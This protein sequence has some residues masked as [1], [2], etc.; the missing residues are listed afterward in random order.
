MPETGHLRGLDGKSV[1]LW[2]NPVRIGLLDRE[3]AKPRA[4]LGYGLTHLHKC[5]ITGSRVCGNTHLHKYV[6]AG[7]RACVIVYL[8]VYGLTDL[9]NYTRVYMRACVAP[10]WELHDDGVPLAS[11]A[12]RGFPSRVSVPFLRLFCNLLTG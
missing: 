9:H 3:M 1:K 12:F 11:P 5:V 7:L 10:I 2:P 8:R 6:D 4:F